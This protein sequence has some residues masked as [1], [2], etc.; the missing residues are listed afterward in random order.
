MHRREE[1][2]AERFRPHAAGYIWKR[3]RAT[4]HAAAAVIGRGEF[5]RCRVGHDP[6]AFQW[7]C[8]RT[9]NSDRSSCV[10]LTRRSL[11]RIVPSATPA[12]SP[13]T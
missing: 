3:N 7:R 8:L 12:T 4:R 6:P 10:I 2:S 1:P 11:R 5:Q 13:P 9:S